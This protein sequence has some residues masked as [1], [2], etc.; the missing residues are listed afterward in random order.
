MNFKCLAVVVLTTIVN[1][2]CS[3]QEILTGTISLRDALEA[4]LAA[5]PSLRSFPLRNEALLGE[6]QIAELKPPFRVGGELEDALGTGN[7]KD[8]R[9]AAATLRLFSVLEMGGKRDARVGAA[10]R[11]IDSLNAEQRVA[12]LDL[13]IETVRRFIEVA[14]AQEHIALQSQSTSIAEQTVNSIQPLVAA[15]QA[16]QL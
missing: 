1:V 16:P 14:A 3:A 13:L 8:F 11:R 9:G 4:T 6:M 7:I 2:T 12:E 10:S 5:N 15:G